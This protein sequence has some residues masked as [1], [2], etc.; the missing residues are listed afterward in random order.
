MAGGKGGTGR[1]MS[2]AENDLWSD[3]HNT[4]NDA[5][6]DDW[7]NTHDPNNDDYLGDDNIG[8]DDS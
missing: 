5:N 4:N 6:M 2:Q 7:A 3:I 8:R 1:G